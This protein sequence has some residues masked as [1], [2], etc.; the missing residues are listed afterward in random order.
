MVADCEGQPYRKR[1]EDSRLEDPSDE[2]SGG[3]RYHE[4]ES[5]PLACWLSGV[6]TLRRGT[7]ERQWDKPTPSGTHRVHP[8]WLPYT[9]RSKRE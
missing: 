9:S 5:D 1:K 6:L 7:R 2:R 3:C 8:V 4:S